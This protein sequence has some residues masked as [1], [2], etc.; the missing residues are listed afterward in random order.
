MEP[1]IL[2]Q[3]DN[4]LCRILIGAAGSF[5]GGL[6]VILFV[7]IVLWHWLQIPLFANL[8]S[9]INSLKGD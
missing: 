2:N 5:L 8:I 6:G 9:T 3:I 7:R 1:I 4:V